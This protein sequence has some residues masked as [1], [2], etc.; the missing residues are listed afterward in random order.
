MD[1]QRQ[2]L[3]LEDELKRALARIKDIIF[4]KAPVILREQLQDMEG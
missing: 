4:R 3:E 1:L 2:V